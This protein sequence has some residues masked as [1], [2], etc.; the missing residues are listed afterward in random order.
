MSS[1]FRIHLPKTGFMKIDFNSWN[2]SNQNSILTN[3]FAARFKKHIGIRGDGCGDF[4]LKR[5]LEE[6]IKGVIEESQ[7]LEGVL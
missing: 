1:T 7:S 3:K 6:M 4:L 2:R 5:E